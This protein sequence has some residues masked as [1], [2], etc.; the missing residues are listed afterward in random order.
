MLNKD[1]LLKKIRRYPKDKLA[2]RVYDLEAQLAELNR[3][4]DKA[5]KYLK[6]ALR[7]INPDK[8]KLSLIDEFYYLYGR[9]L[10]NSTHEKANQSLLKDPIWKMLCNLD[11]MLARMKTP[12]SMMNK[13]NTQKKVKTRK[14]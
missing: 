14:K 6:L 1:K 8:R 4:H 9:Y 5:V 7:R 10:K 13:Y 11:P 12:K 2:S 3:D